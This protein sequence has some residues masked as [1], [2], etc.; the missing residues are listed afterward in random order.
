MLIVF[1]KVSEAQMKKQ[2]YFTIIYR[3]YR[4]T[5][6]IAVIADVV[7]GQFGKDIPGV[8]SL[9]TNSG[10]TGC[11]H[12][13]HSPKAIYILCRQKGIKFL[14]YDYNEPCFGKYQCDH[15]S[16]AAKSIIRSFID[17]GNVLLDEDYIFK[18]LFL[19]WNWY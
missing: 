7:L 1:Y 17:S 6:D 2:I 16:A 8:T 10:N 11:Y 3:C 9:Y 15:E 13:N 18:A 14:S 12:G 4:S 5:A 19:H